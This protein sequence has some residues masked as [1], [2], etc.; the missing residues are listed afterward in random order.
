MNVK[1]EDMVL[2]AVTDRAWLRGETLEEQVEKAIKGGVTFVQLREKECSQSEFLEIANNIKK[3]TDKYRVPLVINDNVEIAIACGADGV[4]IGQSDMELRVARKKLGEKK[5]IGV[6]AKTVEQAI[7]AE[8][9]GA[10]YLGVGA[11]FP[12]TTK[13][14]AHCI[15]ID[16]IKEI[17][18]IIT[19]PVVAIG[20]I[21]KE[22]MLELKG[23][24]IDGVAVI[25]GIF[26]SKNIEQTARELYERSKKL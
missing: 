13:K 4:H 26:A 8:K 1:K 20:G 12:T 2:Y 18:K 11:A 16:T 21:K 7:R 3:V 10:N 9:N 24:G 15:S 17:C 5:I 14:D 22:N 6:S 23:T 19:I 25:S